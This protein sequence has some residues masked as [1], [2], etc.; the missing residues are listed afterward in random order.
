MLKKGQNFA[1]EVRIM[2]LVK[3]KILR[4]PRGKKTKKKTLIMKMSEKSE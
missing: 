1:I 4:I 3:K 2:R